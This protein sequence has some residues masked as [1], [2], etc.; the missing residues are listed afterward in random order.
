MASAACV[1]PGTDARTRDRSCSSGICLKAAGSVGVANVHGPVKSGAENHRPATRKYTAPV[2][3]IRKTSLSVLLTQ[4]SGFAAWSGQVVRLASQQNELRGLEADEYFRRLAGAHLA[5]REARLHVLPVVI[6]GQLLETLRQVAG[7]LP[8]PLHVGR[9]QP[10]PVVAKVVGLGRTVL[11]QIPVGVDR[12]LQVVL[13][14]RRPDRVAVE[15]D[16]H[17]R[18]LAEE[19]LRRIRLHAVDVLRDDLARV[20]VGQHAV[21]RDHALVER[22]RCGDFLHDGP[23]LIALEIRKVGFGDLELGE[24]D[25]PL[26][27]RHAR[28]GLHLDGAERGLFRAL[29]RVGHRRV[30][31][32]LLLVGPARD[33]RLVDDEVGAA[34]RGVAARPPAIWRIGVRRA[35]ALGL[36]AGACAVDERRDR[37]AEQ[38][39]D[40]EQ[41]DPEPRWESGDVPDQHIHS[42][43]GYT[44]SWPFGQAARQPLPEPRPE[45][46]KIGEN[47][48]FAGGA[49][50]KDGPFTIYRQPGAAPR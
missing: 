48:L 4:S 41:S 23:K 12:R 31:N 28:I 45:S 43:L 17:S 20:D 22:H 9:L 38:A 10:D 37:R 21:E 15:V 7:R 42:P 13:R 8:R 29:R 47:R 16:E 49:A 33:L 34:G 30:Q 50:W 35:G 39:H 3:A 6:V 32:G 27:Q 24:A 11:E 18:R 40:G 25:E 26:V 36:A 5:A 14:D 1:V 2:S 19:N 44:F 46:A